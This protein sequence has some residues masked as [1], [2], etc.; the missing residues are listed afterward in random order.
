MNYFLLEKIFSE[1]T[2]I[3]LVNTFCCPLD[4]HLVFFA[5]IESNTGGQYVAVLRSR[6]LNT[7]I[8]GTTMLHS[9]CLL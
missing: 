7:E 3:G 5:L 9:I 4:Y 1:E 6:F 8:L 2:M